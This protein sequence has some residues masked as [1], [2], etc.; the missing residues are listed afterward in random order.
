MNNHFRIR[1]NK[2]MDNKTGMEVHDF[3]LAI[4]NFHM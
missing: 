2:K 3:V 4:L 1:N